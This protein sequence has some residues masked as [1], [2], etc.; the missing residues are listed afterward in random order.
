MNT[1]LVNKLTESERKILE[2]LEEVL[3][4]D[5][6]NSNGNSEQK[7]GTLS[8]EDYWDYVDESED[9]LKKED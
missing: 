8:K 2:E 6:N 1:E 7:E 4:T 3:N 9:N 5:T